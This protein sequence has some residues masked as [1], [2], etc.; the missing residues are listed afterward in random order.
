MTQKLV[1]QFQLH[2][3]LSLCPLGRILNPH[4]R[5]GVEEGQ[6]GT[7]WLTRFRQSAP[8]QLWLHVTHHQQG[9]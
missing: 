7:D 5:L 2:P 8:G 9:K 6:L 4:S 3:S 1:I